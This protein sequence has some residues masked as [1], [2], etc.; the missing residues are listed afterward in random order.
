VIYLRGYLIPRTPTLTKRYFPDRVLRWF[1][2]EPTSISVDE[3]DEMI[4]IDPEQVLLNACAVTPCE[5]GTDL[6][7]RS[8]FQA[9]W[10]ERQHTVRSRNLGSED[11]LEVLAAPPGDASVEEYGDALVAGTDYQMLGQWPSSAAVIADVAAAAELAERYPS[12][13]RLHPAERARVLTSL[14]IF[15]EECPECDS[16][17]RIEQEVVDSCCMSHDVIVSAC[18]DCDAQLFEIEWDD[19][20]A[21]TLDAPDGQLEVKQPSQVKT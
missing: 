4:R 12:W 8:D 2:K 18:Q 5:S 7:A 9:S 10:R 20:L 3:S 19:E 1:D 13:E 16:P 11:V 17:V 15:I 21:T 6:C 14:R